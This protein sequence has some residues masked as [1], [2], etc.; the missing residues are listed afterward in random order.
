MVLVLFAA[1]LLVFVVVR[2]TPGDPAVVQ[3]GIHAGD[4]RMASELQAIRVE[5][6]LNRP[7]P[8]QYVIWLGRIIRGNFGVSSSSNIG[9]GTIILQ[10]LPASIELIVAG[11]LLGLL[12]ALPLSILSAL[13]HNTWIDRLVSVTVVCGIAIPVFW[14]G[15]LLILLFSVHFGWLPPGGYTPFFDN[16]WLN[17]RELAMPATS[18]ALYEAALFTRFLRAELLDVLQQDYVRVAEA[19]GLP[20]WLIMG[21]HVLKNALI[22]LLT[23]LG[24]EIGALFS[25]TLINEQIFGW[26]G[27]GW[28]TYQAINSRDYALLQGV[29][30]VIAV[31][32]SFSNLL[33][34]IAYA[35]VNPRI[36]FHSAPN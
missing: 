24:L 29:V 17:L 14:L 23:V 13:N 7:V 12:I 2:L 25:N 9:V 36:R 6:G 21:R 5:L 8:V 31:I 4:P 32:F 20:T 28:L 30:L 26:S 22:S 34:D 1:S 33:T 15:L 18:L 27:V 19:K 16:P 35:F 3:L 11:L 10:K